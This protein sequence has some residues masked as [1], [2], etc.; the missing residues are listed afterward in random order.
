[1]APGFFT[2]MYGNVCAPH[3][4]PIKSESHCVWLRPPAA[5][6]ST[7]T[8]PRYVFCPRPAEMPFDTILLFVF[9]PMWII[10]VPL[11]ACWRWCV[12][13]TELN[14][15]TQSSPRSTQ[16]GYFHVIAEPVSTCVHEILLRAPRQSP[17]LVTKVE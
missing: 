2:S 10:L 13:A 5:P 15:P 1:M 16:L 7:L 8:S 12:N 9:L 4:L 3:F 6:F 17:R 11:S 14:S